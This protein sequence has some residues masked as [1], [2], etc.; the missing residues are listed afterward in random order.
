MLHDMRRSPTDPKHRVSTT[1]KLKGRNVLFVLLGVAALVIVRHYSGPFVE[2]V[3]S[4]GGNVSAS[5]AVYFILRN[6]ALNRM[7]GRL[8]SATAALLVVCLF[9]V[10]D[11]F[12]VMTNVYD[13]L[14]VVANALGIGLALAV[15]AVAPGALRMTRSR[16]LT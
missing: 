4:Y 14:D 6:L 2:I 1:A 3:H 8:L 7:Y 5:F 15:D 10:T 13:P 9:E 12:G 16:D 11:G